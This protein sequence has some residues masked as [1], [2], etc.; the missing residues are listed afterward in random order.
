MEPVVGRPLVVL[1]KKLKR[2]K[3][4]LKQFHKE[5]YANMNDRIKKKRG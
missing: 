1:Q 5:H 3:T 4:V 2:L